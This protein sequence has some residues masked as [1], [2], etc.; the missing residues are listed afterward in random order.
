L[1]SSIDG[2]GQR[3]EQFANILKAGSSPWDHPGDRSPQLLSK[4]RSDQHGVEFSCALLTEG[5][6]EW[7][8]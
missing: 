8:G 4:Q 2:L 6:Q 1:L 7:P 5:E 3:L